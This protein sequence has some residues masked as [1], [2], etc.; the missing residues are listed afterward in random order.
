M[1]AQNL[2]F[3]G[4][5]AIVTGAGQGMGRAHAK[6]RA[7]RGARVVVNDLNADNAASAVAEIIA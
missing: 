1:T 5:V 3:G 4:R 6:M 7:S 2:D